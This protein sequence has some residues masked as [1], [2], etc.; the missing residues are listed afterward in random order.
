MATAPLTTNKMHHA[1]GHSI[2]AD[3]DI[4]A[5]GIDEA[6]NMPIK[7]FVMPPGG[8]DLPSGKMPG[9]ALPTGG[10][11]FQPGQP[12]ALGQAPQAPQQPAPGQQPQSAPQQAPGQPAA[13]QQPSNILNMTHQGASNVSDDTAGPIA[14]GHAAAG[15]S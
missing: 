5:I 13:P 2:G 9:G 3:T 11:S 7:T 6:P 15:V 10:V 1:I 4:R 14:P 12:G 8:E